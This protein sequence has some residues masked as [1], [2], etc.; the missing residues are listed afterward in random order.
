MLPDERMVEAARDA[1]DA[2]GVELTR[3]VIR[4][5]LKCAFIALDRVALIEAGASGD[6]LG[7]GILERHTETERRVIAAAVLR[8]VGL[9]S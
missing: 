7:W 5:M 1:G 8:A 4:G 3:D 2:M 6:T 9:I